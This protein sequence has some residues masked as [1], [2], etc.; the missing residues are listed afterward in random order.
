MSIRSILPALC[1][2]MISCGKRSAVPGEFIQPAV[3]QS[4]LWDY[5]RA[6]ALTMQLQKNNTGTP[7]ALAENVKLQKQVFAIHQ[8]SKEEFYRSLNFYKSHP[9]LMRTIMDSIVNKANRERQNNA[10]PVN[11]N[12]A[13]IKQY[14]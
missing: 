2:L 11:L 4:V 14:E 13:L 9:A 6:D 3:M 12:P 7:E 5:I 10:T 8:V 1:I